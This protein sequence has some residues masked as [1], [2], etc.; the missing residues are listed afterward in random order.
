MLH[1]SV[2][3]KYDDNSTQWL[4]V[5]TIRTHAKGKNGDVLLPA[6]NYWRNK[7]VKVFLVGTIEGH[8][9]V[10]ITFYIWL[11][12]KLHISC[13]NWFCKRYSW[14]FKCFHI[15]PDWA[16]VNASFHLTSKQEFENL[17]PLLEE[18]GQCVSWYVKM[19]SII[20][21]RSKL[22]RD[23]KKLCRTHHCTKMT[24]NT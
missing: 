7:L 20:T 16:K 1:E 15:C 17:C 9:K 4:P 18:K 10:W 21:V 14:V 23:R 6:Q 19:Q 22:Q 2:E 3:L 8:Y 24:Q 5:S 13:V 12:V 11:P